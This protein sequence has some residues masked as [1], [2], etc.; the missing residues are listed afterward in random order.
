MTTDIAANIRAELLAA[1]LPIKADDV[2]NHASDLYVTA[3]PGVREWIANKFPNARPE[4]FLDNQGRRTYE[5]PFALVGEYIESRRQID[6]YARHV[7]RPGNF[8]V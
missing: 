3:L 6:G 8:P 4:L 2:S 7:G 1:G 5:I